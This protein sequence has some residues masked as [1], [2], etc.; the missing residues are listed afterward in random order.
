M[1]TSAVRDASV[2]R[3]VLQ[4]LLLHILPCQMRLATLRCSGYSLIGFRSSTG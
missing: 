4:V 2:L 3:W 1:L